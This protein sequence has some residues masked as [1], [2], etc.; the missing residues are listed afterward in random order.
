M[1]GD[2]FKEKREAMGMTQAEV[3]SRLCMAQSTIGQVEAN[4]KP[5]S[6]GLVRAAAEL[7]GCSSDDFIFWDRK[8][9]G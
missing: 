1:M 4:I 3:A 5:P 2:V 8:Q 6:V 7:F 9:A